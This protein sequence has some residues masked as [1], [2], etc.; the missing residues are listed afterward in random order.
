VAAASSCKNLETAFLVGFFRIQ[1]SFSSNFFFL[2]M[3]CLVGV[4]LATSWVPKYHAVMQASNE[5]S[6][7]AIQ[8]ALRVDVTPSVSYYA[9]SFPLFPFFNEK[10][11]V[12]FHFY[13]YLN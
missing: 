11:C 2:V 10:A 9:M 4:L 7:Q 8:L 3:N 12:I 13:I 5:T 6:G 1:L